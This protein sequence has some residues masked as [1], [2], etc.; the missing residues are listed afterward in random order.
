MTDLRRHLQAGDPLR[1]EPALAP[2]HIERMRR[3]IVTAA[4]EPRTRVSATA[5]ALVA[6]L[7]SAAAAG[8]WLVGGTSAT[9]TSGTTTFAANAGEP[10]NAPRRQVQF[11]TPGGTRLIWVFNPQFES[12]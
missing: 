8:V 7:A 2:D 1:H 6:G 4:G 11:S 10:A 9:R 12:R 3:V 5:F